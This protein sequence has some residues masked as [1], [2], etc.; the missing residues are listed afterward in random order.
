M[1]KKPKLKELYINRQMTGP[2][3]AELAGVKSSQTI[4]NW[5]D[6]YGIPRRQGREAQRPITPNKETLQE[7]YIEQEL[8]IDQIGRMLGSSESSIS[9]LLDQY[10]I[11]KRERWEKMAG[12]NKGQSIPEKQRQHLSEIARQRTGT[13]SPRYGVELSDETKQKISNSLKGRFRGPDNPQWKGGSAN[14]RHKWHSRY[15]YKE[16][17]NA[18][19]ERDGY[20]CQMCGKPSEGDI[21]AHHIYPWCDYPDRRLDVG[22]GITLCQECHLSIKGKEIEYVEQFLGIIRQPTP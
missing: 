1:L 18:I 12:W 22:N 17:R 10:G 8:S 3:I 9:K 2:E 7:L 16:W 15:E 20:T 5:L 13:D 21:E 4:Y 19:F 14:K 11:P 6:K